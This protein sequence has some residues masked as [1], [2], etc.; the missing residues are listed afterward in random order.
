MAPRATVCPNCG[1]RVTP[2]AAGCAGCGA[3]LEAH[4]AELRAHP[5][6]LT[7]LVTW[8]PR[9]PDVQLDATDLAM[10]AVTLLLAL[11]APLYGLLLALFC[12]WAKHREG[13]LAVRNILFG[14]AAL[15]L[16]GMLFPF[17]VL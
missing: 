7:R 3:D 14:L 1:E 12:A 5:P 11:F 6:L 10:L 17:A 13:D 16:V 2:F 15:A 9:V 4:R 8:R